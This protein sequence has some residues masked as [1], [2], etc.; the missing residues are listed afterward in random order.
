MKLKNC[1]TE[2]WCNNFAT[3]NKH[4]KL[5]VTILQLKCNNCIFNV[6]KTSVSEKKL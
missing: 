4:F 5:T 6:L 2:G 1:D 3:T